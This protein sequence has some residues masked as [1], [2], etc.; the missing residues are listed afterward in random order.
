MHDSLLKLHLGIFYVCDTLKHAVYTLQC[1]AGLAADSKASKQP[2]ASHASAISLGKLLSLIAY[3]GFL[4]VSRGIHTPLAPCAELSHVPS[5]QMCL[6]STQI[7]HDVYS[8]E[9]QYYTSLSRHC[10]VFRE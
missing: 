6:H 1:T 2:T 10:H 7:W 9:P 3:R 8:L 5:C 4:G